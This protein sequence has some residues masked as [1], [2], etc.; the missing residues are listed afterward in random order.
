MLGGAED[1]LVGTARHAPALNEAGERMVEAA[2]LARRFPQ[3]KI[4]FSGGDAGILYKSSSE[5]EGA[6]ALLTA[7]GVPRERLIL[8]A[9]A[10]DTY[11]NAVFLKE[12]LA[13]AGSLAPARAG[14]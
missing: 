3:A 2:M 10:R 9:N 11:E 8:E 1:R 12:E 6:A 5:A 7:L 13:K 14:C 4:A